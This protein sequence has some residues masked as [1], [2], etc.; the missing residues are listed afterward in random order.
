MKTFVFLHDAFQGGWIWQDA[1]R[2]L[3]SLGCE[4]YT[5]SFT[6]CGARRH[7]TVDGSPRTIYLDD[8]ESLFIY[9]NISQAALVC[10]GYAGMLAPLLTRR[11]GARVQAIIFLEAALP[12]K[13]ESFMDLAQPPLAGRLHKHTRNDMVRPTE[14]SLFNTLELGD[15]FQDRLCPFPLRAFT[16]AYDG[17]EPARWPPSVYLY[18]GA[19]QTPF[20]T[21]MLARARTRGLEDRDCALNAVPVLARFDEIARLLDTLVPQPSPLP[22]N[23]GCGRPRMPEHMRLL[24]C[25]RYRQRMALARVNGN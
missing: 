23:E 2:S 13:G 21:A 5:P 3:R 8:I 15:Y 4:A 1:A 16:E 25:P 18:C 22:S 7:L 14:P 10:H 11:L 19:N 12:E 6:G 24:H 17:L 20:N 9:E